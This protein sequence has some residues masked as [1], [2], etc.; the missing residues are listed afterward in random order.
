MFLSHLSLPRVRTPV[1]LS[2]SVHSYRSHVQ[3]IQPSCKPIVNIFNC[4]LTSSQYAQR[5]FEML[6]RRYCIIINVKFH[7]SQ[8][9]KGL[10]STLIY[11]FPNPFK[12]APIRGI[13]AITYGIAGQGWTPGS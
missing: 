3:P 6:P 1:Y 4:V 9:L 13:H 10:G 12:A 7:H 8:L 11:A 2:A 5:R